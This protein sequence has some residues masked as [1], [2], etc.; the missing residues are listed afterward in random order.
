M[1]TST[2]QKAVLRIDDVRAITGLSRTAIYDKENRRS[3][4]FD[5]NFPN[6]FKLGERSVGWDAREIDAWVQ[7]KK[8]ARTS[9]VH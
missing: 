6:R 1:N 4:Y 9:L 2:G 3:K 8:A 5:P 7:S